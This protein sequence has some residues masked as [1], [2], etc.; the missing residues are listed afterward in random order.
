MT[1]LPNA[2]RVR[3]W[4]AFLDQA[5]HE[6]GTIQVFSPAWYPNRESPVPSF[7]PSGEPGTTRSIKVMC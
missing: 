1:L 5:W 3:I 2:D 4:N 7:G 6:A